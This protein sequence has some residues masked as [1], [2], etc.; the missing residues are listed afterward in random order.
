MKK[1]LL[2]FAVLVIALV[3]VLSSCSAEMYDDGD[4]RAHAETMLDAILADDFDTAY[5]VI[6]DACTE[7]EFKSFYNQIRAELQG[8]TN[9][10]LECISYYTSYNVSNGKQFERTDVEYRFNTGEREYVIAVVTATGYKNLAGFN[11]VPVENTDL[12]Y[13]GT[14]DNMVGTTP[15]QWVMILFN[16]PV[17]AFTV[18]ALVDCARRRI[19]KKA[20]WIIVILLGML[21]IGITTAET[22]SRFNLGLGLFY[23]SAL[24]VYGS[25]KTVFRL[26]LPIGAIVYFAMRK[27]LE[28]KEDY[29]SPEP[30]YEQQFFAEEENAE[31]GSDGTSVYC[32]KCGAENTS[33]AIFCSNCGEKLKNE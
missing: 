12:Y 7:P 13:N 32:T 28:I 6:S 27:T 1:K 23:Y 30:A 22:G 33:D 20:L 16:L 18:I 17:L 9:Y 5:A 3:L 19:K 21:L 2:T 4:I 29:Q 31:Q 8:V 25:G 26:L 14:L 11:L 24:I 10:E 15:F